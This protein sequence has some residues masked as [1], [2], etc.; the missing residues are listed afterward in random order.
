MKARFFT[1]GQSLCGFEVSGHAGYADKGEDIVCAA[2][3]S[4][5]QLTVNTI[6]ESIGAGAYVSRKGGQITLRLLRS[7]DSAK[8]T[9]ARA[10][11]NGLYLHLF[12]LGTQY[13]NTISIED[14]EV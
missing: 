13:P 11:I 7:E 1:S 2:V 9:A 12:I 5:V 14:S 8:L 3:S 6:I 10:V 4:A